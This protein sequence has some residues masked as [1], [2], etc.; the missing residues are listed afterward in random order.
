[1]HYLDNAASTRPCQAAVEAAQHCM[2]TCFGNPSSLHAAGR[3]ARDALSQARRQTA[4]ALDAAPEDLVFTSGGTEACNLALLGAAGPLARRGGHV[5]VSTLEHAAVAECARHLQS[6]GFSLTSLPPD[7]DGRLSADSVVGAMK[8]DTVLVSLMLVSNDTG[9]VNPLSDIVRAVRKTHPNVIIHTDAVQGFLKVPCVPATLGVDLLT[10]SAHKIG[11]LKGAGALW[12]RPGLRLTPQVLGGGHEEGLRAGT[13][14][15][16]ALAAFGAACASRKATFE[17]DVKHMRTLKDMLLLQLAALPGVTV[18]APHDAPHIVTL[19]LPGY[20]SEVMLR[21]L[22]DGGVYVSSGSACH[23][24]RRS[25]ALSS[26]G[27]CARILDSVLRVSFCPD[28]TQQ[29]VEALLARLRAGMS[30]LV[31]I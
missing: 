8:P 18:I 28:N 3:S 29:D 15:V 13:E 25:E 26:M 19:S 21:Y 27:L 9:A 12:R 24:G 14:A 6:I 30:T 20:P 7:K 10:V 23:K 17:Q 5:I 1:M 11:A 22:S 31:H 2:T 16:P 4:H